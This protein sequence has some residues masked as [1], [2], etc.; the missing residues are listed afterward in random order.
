MQHIFDQHTGRYRGVEYDGNIIRQLKERNKQD[1]PQ[2][3]ADKQRMQASVFGLR[4]LDSFASRQKLI[5]S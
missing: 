3:E 2:L 4:D 1:A 5:I